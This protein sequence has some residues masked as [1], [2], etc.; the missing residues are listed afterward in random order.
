MRSL[1]L[2]R[3]FT[4]IAQR[5]VH[6]YEALGVSVRLDPLYP[7]PLSPVYPRAVT[8]PLARPCI[9]NSNR[10][11]SPGQALPCAPDARPGPA[12]CFRNRF[13][14]RRACVCPRC[15]QP[16]RR[17]A[18]GPGQFTPPLCAPVLLPVK[19]DTYGASVRVSHKGRWGREDGTEH[20][21]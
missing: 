21:Q 20:A 3:K 4:A 13:C 12:P 15:P 5:T 16:H 1:K 19:R 2:L 9:L 8:R 18:V 11:V 10:R 17:F 14:R 7:V 6:L